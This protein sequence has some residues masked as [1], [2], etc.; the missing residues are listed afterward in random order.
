MKPELL[1]LKR[2]QTSAIETKISYF[3]AVIDSEIDLPYPRNFVCQF[4]QV[5]KSRESCNEFS[6]IFGSQS[7][8]VAKDLLIKALN[9]ESDPKIKKMIE[10]RLSLLFR[11]RAQ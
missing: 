1:I 2:K 11:S 7:T 6:K 10:K 8:D 5:G 9:R 3:F 4:P